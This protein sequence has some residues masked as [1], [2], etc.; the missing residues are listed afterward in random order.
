MTKNVNKENCIVAH[1]LFEKLTHSV[2]KYKGE[3][4]KLQV[5]DKRNEN[6]RKRM[7]SISE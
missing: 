7:G 1:I 2:W 6:S 5:T 3:N 4:C